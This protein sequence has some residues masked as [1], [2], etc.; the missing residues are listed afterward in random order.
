MVRQYSTGQTPN[1]VSGPLHTRRQRCQEG[2]APSRNGPRVKAHRAR[3]EAGVCFIVS[4][5]ITRR[6]L[7]LP[8]L[9]VDDRL[10]SRAP[11]HTTHPPADSNWL[12][13]C[14]MT[15]EKASRHRSRQ[16]GK[17]VST[18]GLPARVGALQRTQ[19]PSGGA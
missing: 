13:M 9:H 18:N 14:R 3:V 15:A 1:A 6:L 12:G 8:L 17:A 11:A 5:A 4:C 2:E 19:A 7:L 10:R 16:Q